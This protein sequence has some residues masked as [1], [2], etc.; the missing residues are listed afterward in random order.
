[1]L[2]R[3][4]P[5]S[6]GLCDYVSSVRINS[7][8]FKNA[9]WKGSAYNCKSPDSLYVVKY[10]TITVFILSTH[11]RLCHVFFCCFL[12]TLGNVFLKATNLPWEP[13]VCKTSCSM[14]W[15]LSHWDK[16]VKGYTHAH[17]SLALGHSLWRIFT[18]MRKMKREGGVLHTC[19]SCIEGVFIN[20]I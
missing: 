9:R 13:T 12:Q 10:I 7:V 20:L 3:L 1:M 4:E 6:S 17:Y 5:W 11:V 14:L 18:V 16:L 15:Y 19:D 2:C 8:W